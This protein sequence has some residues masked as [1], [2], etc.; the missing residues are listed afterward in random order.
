ML[1]VT[2]PASETALGIDFANVFRN[3]EPYRSVHV[4]VSRNSNIKNIG[5]IR[6]I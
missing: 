2:A 1:E 5:H 6:K 3:S 4:A